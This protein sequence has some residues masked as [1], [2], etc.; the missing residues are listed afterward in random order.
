MAKA[1]L[2]RFFSWVDESELLKANGVD[3][4][5]LLAKFHKFIDKLTNP[6]DVE[7]FMEGN[8]LSVGLLCFVP[9]MLNQK[10]GTVL[11]I[12]YGQESKRSKGKKGGG[13]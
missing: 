13:A 11:V 12:G 6:R 5:E 7:T 3:G 4:K 10:D 1:N 9:F 8:G 2:G